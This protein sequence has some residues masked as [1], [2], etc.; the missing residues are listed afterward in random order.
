MSYTPPDGD[1][2][3]FTWVGVPTYAPPDGD[4]LDFS[5]VP[6][7][8]TTV[9]GDGALLLDFI[10]EGSGVHGTATQ[11]DGA[12]VLDFAPSG[13]GAVG[14]VG[15]GAVT[16]DFAAAASGLHG[17]TGYGSVVLNLTGAGAAQHTRYELR[18]EVRLGGV[19]V[20]RRVRAYLRS[21][22]ALVSQA[23]TVAGKFNLPAGFAEDEFYVTPI[24]LDSGA[25][26]WKPP[27]A[28]RVLSVLADDAA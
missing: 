11:G 2:V 24:D 22:G 5:F 18:G 17:I 4:A 1:G 14:V 23:D 13:E 19:L 27:T 15:T 10:A 26:D 20:N 8:P 9:E 3:D 21:S 7:G 12:L 28:N 6:A 16:L 25:T